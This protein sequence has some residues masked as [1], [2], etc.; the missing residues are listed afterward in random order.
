[1]FALPMIIIGACV[2]LSSKGN[3]LFVQKRV[4]RGGQLFDIYK[5]RSMTHQHEVHFGPGLTNDDDQ[6]VTGFGRILRRFKLDELPQFINVLQGNM[7][8]VGPRPKL[9]QYAAIPNMP[10]RP[11]ITGL[12]TIVFRRE[13]EIL[14]GVAAGE[15]DR[16]YSDHIKPLKARL[17]VC[18][19]CK[20]TL[21]SDLR[22]I[23]STV[24]ESLRP[25]KSPVL[26]VGDVK[27]RVL[28]MISY[29]S[30]VPEVQ[31]WED[32]SVPT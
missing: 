13:E 11:G 26:P 5:F 16:F 32:P 21:A 4:G 6:R 24:I 19:M 29:E 27:S 23:A 9:L 22:V 14:R 8:L 31:S 3:A 20:A 30:A 10:Y 1:M 15:I 2:R 28:A 17:D 7:S 18:Y 12:A 25:G